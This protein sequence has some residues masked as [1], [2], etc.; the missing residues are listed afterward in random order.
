MSE[1]QRKFAILHELI[2]E[3]VNTA[4]PVGSEALRKRLRL[5]WSPATIRNDLAELEAE[6]YV[7]KP[8][9]S[10]GRIPTDKAYRHYVN[11]LLEERNHL[12]QKS[13]GRLKAQTRDLEEITS[14]DEMVHAAAKLMARLTK[15]L[16][17]G[18]ILERKAVF[19]SG[20]AQLVEE[21]EFSEQDRVAD[22]ARF[23][24]AFA[25]NVLVHTKKLLREDLELYIGEENPISDI[26][27]C[28][29]LI[30]DFDLPSGEQ[31]FIAMIGPTRMPYDRNIGLLE[32][33]RDLLEN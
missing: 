32:S 14:P 29:M 10:G 22:V 31:G 27:S 28:S 25:D 18:G 1:A 3:Y 9:T 13:T 26:R 16:V 6:G 11:Q 5:P 7:A 8:H 23:M 15:H 2:K 4:E 21:P 30:S 20:L 24:E 19:D 12:E 33:V 17:L